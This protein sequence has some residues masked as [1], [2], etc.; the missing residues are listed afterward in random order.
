[1]ADNTATNDITQDRIVTKRSITY[2]DNYA[3]IDF[4]VKLEQP[5]HLNLLLNDFID[6]FHDVKADK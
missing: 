3:K 5:D 1:M 2:A 4:S 6:G